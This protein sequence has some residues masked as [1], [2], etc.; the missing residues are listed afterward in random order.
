MPIL[1]ILLG[2]LIGASIAIYG[3]LTVQK[4]DQSMTARLNR[5]DLKPA[6]T[7]AELELQIPR[8]E[9][10]LGPARRR[11]ARTVRNFTPNGAIEGMQLKL[12]QA[13][14][15]RNLTVQE[16]LGYK[17]LLAIAGAVIGFLVIT[18]LFHQGLT[19]M[20]IVMAGAGWA[21]YMAPDYY[22]RSEAKKRQDEIQK[23]LAD[24]I[25]ILAISV[26]AG[27]GFDGA[28]ETLSR[29][30]KNHLTY[31]FDRFR[32]EVQAGKGRKEAFRD[33]AL[34]TGVADLSNFVAAMIQ[35]DQLGIGISQVL[36]AQS[37]ELRIKRRQRAEEKAHQAP[38]KMLFPLIFLM[39]PALF[40]VI[41]GPAV[42]SLM[43]FGG[44]H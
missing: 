33:L 29:R 9:R 38:I 24:A 44:T 7:L 31:E 18:L 37:E 12:A 26:E 40:I 17:G 10:L 15:P 20:V 36:R 41:L 35:A 28:L 30:K 27:Q 2:V 14:N 11:V 6:G 8:V 39:F 1:I 5:F 43:S 21:G 16:I 32:L 19:V 34:R 13:G 42:P 25:D 23:Y 3:A 4:L 22:L